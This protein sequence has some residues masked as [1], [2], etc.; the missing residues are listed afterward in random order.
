MFIEALVVGTV[1]GLFRGG[2]LKSLKTVHI[3]MSGMLV[4]AFLLH[5]LLAF[6]LLVANPF[7][8]EHRLVFYA[9]SYGLLFIALLMNLTHKAVWLIIIGCLMNFTVLFLSE[10]V[11][12]VSAEALERA[13][14]E[15]RLEMIRDDRLI[16]YQFSE[17]MGGWRALLGK[18]I[19][20]PAWY[21]VRQVMSIGDLVLSAGLL[22]WM[23]RLMQGGAH[24]QRARVIR[25]DHKGKI[26]K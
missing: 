21:P 18:R 2:S 17:E 1:V 12:P 10:G 22:L 8:V 11:L 20:P 26:W 23:Q 19:T 7:F 15:N 5:V 9:I 3:R 4:L 6:M 14:F 25:I 16:Q 13:G 24:Y